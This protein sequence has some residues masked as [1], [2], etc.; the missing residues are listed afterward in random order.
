M[1]F[2]LGGQE[3][4]EQSVVITMEIDF[5]GDVEVLANGAPIL[6]ICRDGCILLN[7]CDAS[8]LEKLGF[9]EGEDGTVKVV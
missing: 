1:V 9:A 7:D 4:R 3:K 8:V 2:E 5:E 6:W